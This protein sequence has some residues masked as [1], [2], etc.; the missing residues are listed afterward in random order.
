M[1]ALK[2]ITYSDDEEDVGS[3]ADFSNLETNITTVVA[4]SSIKA[5]YVAAA[6][7]ND[8]RSKLM[9]FGLTI[10][11]AHLMLLDRK[12]VII[13]EDSIRQALRLYDA[14]SVACLPNEEIFA[15]LARMEY[16]KPSTKGLPGM[17]LVLPWLRLLSAYQ[18]DVEDAAKDEYVVNE[19]FVE[20]TSPS[21]TPA[22]PPPSPKQEHI[23]SLPQAT[24][25]DG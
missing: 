21:P 14:D 18:Q 5:K 1:P 16:E 12:K 4:T 9:L 8:V 11:V 3:E 25:A 22:T 20:S 23:P 6:I 10:D 2:G 19:V 7:I 24:T 15:K 17:N 13:T